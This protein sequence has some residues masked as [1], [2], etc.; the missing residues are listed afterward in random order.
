MT[1]PAQNIT[2][3]AIMNAPNV[4]DITDMSD[5]E[6][7]SLLGVEETEETVK[8]DLNIHVARLL[9]K[10]PFFAA[11]SRRI[12]KRASTALPTAGVRVNPETAQFEMLYNPDFFAKLT[13]DERAD[14]LKHEFYHIIFEHVTGDRFQSFADMD[15]ADAR[16]H[17]IAMDLAINSHLP[18]LPEG[19]C[20]PGIEGPF[21]GMPSGKTAEWY[22]ANLPENE[23]EGQG[24]GQGQGEGQ[25][26]GQG[27]G[28]FDDHSMWG[29]DAEAN[30][31]AK[32]RLKD[33]MKKASEEASRSGG[34]GTVPSD[35]RKDILDRLSTKIDWRKVLRY[36]IKTSQRSDKRST[37]KRIN[38][39]YP[40]IH[41]GRKVNRHAKI[42]ISIDQSGSVD[43]GMLA[44]FFAELNQ[45]ADL[46][47]FTV[48]PFDTRVAEDKVYVWKK[49]ERRKRERVMYGGTD[50][51]P[52]T[53]YV[54]ERAF[55][56]HIILTDLMAPKPIASKCQRMWMTTKYHADN[57][58]FKTNERVIAV[59]DK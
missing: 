16:R 5:G 37:V 40:Y 52:P 22:L 21:A 55:D 44:L 43:D 6:L 41:P 24:N 36:F 32:E 27:N 47:E 14:V 35:V 12:D 1:E 19:A 49:G 51:N 45:L 9:M 2:E 7:D 31:I 15:P 42:A 20:K 4:T 8:F 10:E 13:D 18:N 28:Q 17:N 38:K 56:G 34:W 46:A 11:L 53:K 59:D 26:E 25:G 30:D 50:F 39:R 3:E 48:I 33:V 29:G 23:G 54:N 57:P 58:Y